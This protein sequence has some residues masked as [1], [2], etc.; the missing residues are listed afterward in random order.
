MTRHIPRW[1]LPVFGVFVLG[2]SLA[3]RGGGTDSDLRIRIPD[4]SAPAGGA[5]QM[6]LMTTEVSPISGGR[7]LFRFSASVFDSVLGFGVF[8]PD[9]EAAGAAIVDGNQVQVSYITT[10]PTAGEYPLMSITMPIRAD[11]APGTQTEFA[12]DPASTWLLST[13]G[14]TTTARVSPGEV[15]VAGSVSITD[16]VPGEGLAP[17]GAVIS[18]RGIGFRKDTRLRVDAPTRSVQFVSATEMRVTLG[19]PTNLIGLEFRATNP[20]SS[21]S[22]YLAYMRGVTRTVSA[23]TLLAMTKPIFGVRS[24]EVATFAS[25]SPLDAGQYAAIAVQN[26]NA[27]AVDVKLSLVANHGTVLYESVRT[28]DSQER[29]ALEASEWLDGVAPPVGS[30]IVVS[31]SAP[32]DAISLLCDEGRWTVAASLPL[33]AQN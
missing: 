5:V 2:I 30:S 20:D 29:R 24:R 4:E 17:A 19:A 3:A 27:D 8:N 14:T 31:A 7:P 21:R 25:A 23:R 16:I 28:L 1:P 6:K 33:E 12:I 9:G 10:A 18:V 26:P 11:A 32:I 13:S 15:T 22:I